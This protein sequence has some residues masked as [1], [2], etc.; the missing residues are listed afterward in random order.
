MHDDLRR[1]LRTAS[2]EELALRLE[3]R[4][5]TTLIDVRERSET[6]EGIIPGALCIPHAELAHEL[7]AR[8]VD[9]RTP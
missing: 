2:L 1:P 4:D 5:V 3:R 6:E 9:R 7:Q 8:G